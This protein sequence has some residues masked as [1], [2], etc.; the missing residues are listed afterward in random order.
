MFNTTMFSGSC[1]VSFVCPQ[2]GTVQ[3]HDFLPALQ[4]SQFI[5]AN[6][7]FA[8]CPHLCFCPIFFSFS[9]SPIHLR[10]VNKNNWLVLFWRG[11]P[12]VWYTR[13]FVTTGTP[14][15]VVLT[16]STRHCVRQLYIP[17]VI[18]RETWSTVACWRCGTLYLYLCNQHQ[19]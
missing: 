1:G 7:L 19:C 8:F 9:H 4:L 11:W 13:A 3:Q 18:S 6:T 2:G 14:V 15:L 5:M 12:I 16:Y 17:G 10:S